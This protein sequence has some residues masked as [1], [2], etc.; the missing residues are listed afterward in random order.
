MFKRFES[1]DQLVRVRSAAFNQF[2]EV[3]FQDF[4]RDLGKSTTEYCHQ[5]YHTF[6]KISSAQNVAL[7]KAVS[8]LRTLTGGAIDAASIVVKRTDGPDPLSG[9][10]SLHPIATTGPSSSVA[11]YVCAI[12]SS[13][14]LT[15]STN[16]V[17][18]VSKGDLE[19]TK[20]NSDLRPLGLTGSAAAFVS[21]PYRASSAVPKRIKK[22]ALW[23][24]RLVLGRSSLQVVVR[25]YS[26]IL[27]PL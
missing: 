9:S 1:L 16:D 27:L 12:L 10:G 13:V 2:F 21:V 19:A 15:K 8:G 17:S 23:A 14:P 6:L 18:G 24:I 3:S 25:S 11:H 5:L 26:G 4:S 22:P 7:R 20:S